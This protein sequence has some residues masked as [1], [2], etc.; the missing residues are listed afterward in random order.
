MIPKNRI[1]D[2]DAHSCYL[3]NMIDRFMRSSDT[4]ICEYTS[5]MAWSVCK[6]ICVR[7]SA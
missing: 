5:A 3:T 6:S 4:A 2:W 7:Q 1:I